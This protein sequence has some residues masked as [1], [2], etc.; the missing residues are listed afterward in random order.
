MP[1]AASPLAHL[2]FDAELRRRGGEQI[3]R[4]QELLIGGGDPR[5]RRHVADFSP[6]MQLGKKKEKAAGKGKKQ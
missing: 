1:L 2:D 4:R 6:Q 5:R 3:A